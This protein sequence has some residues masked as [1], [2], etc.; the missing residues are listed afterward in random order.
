MP[1][2]VKLLCLQEVPIQWVQLP[3]LTAP[4]GALLDWSNKSDFHYLEIS[5]IFVKALTHIS[6]LLE[7]L[8]RATRKKTKHIRAPFQ[9]SREPGEEQ[10]E[11]TELIAVGTNCSL[12]SNIDID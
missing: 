2:N 5:C 8:E 12:S 7:I 9:L 1:P 6:M 3:V 11:A 10:R 4:I